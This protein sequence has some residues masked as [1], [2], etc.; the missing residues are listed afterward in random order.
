MEFKSL[1]NIETSFKQIRLYALLFVLL[2]IAVCGYALYASYSF[3]S[4]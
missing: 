3:A 1:T 2:C 4:Q